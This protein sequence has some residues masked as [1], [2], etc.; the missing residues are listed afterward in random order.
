MPVLT[1][2][3]IKKSEEAAVNSGSFTYYELM[4]NAGKAAGKAILE[5]YPISG[6]RVAVLCGSGNNGGDG[7]VVAKYLYE[8]GTDVTVITPFGMPQTENASRCYSELGNINK[9]C[10]FTKDFDIIVDALFGIGFNREPEQHVKELFRMINESGAVKISVDIPSGVETDTGKVFGEAIIADLTLTFIA[11]KPCFVLPQGSDHCGKVEVLD[12]GVKPIDYS[13]GIIE[14]PV[15]EKRRH[16]SHKG[17]YGTALLICGSYGM[18]GAAMLAAKATLRSGAGL[19]KC[20]IPQ[21]IYAPFTAFIP[22]AVCLPLKESKNG[23]LKFNQTALTKQIDSAD[24]IL[25]GCGLGKGRDITKTLKFLIENSAKPLIIDAD[26]INSITD[27]IEIL[28][29][30]KA[31]IILTPHPGE[32]ARLCKKSVAEIESDR[33]YYAKTFATENNCTLVLKGSNT[34]V[35]E[36]D[37]SISFS[38]NGNPGM[39]TGGSGDVLSGIMVSLAAQGLPAETAAKY[40][41][42]LHAAAGDKAAAEKGQHA[43]LP[44]DIIEKL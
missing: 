35:A 22:E 4:Q 2:E 23:V 24:A 18:A 21:S 40:A 1:K 19:A 14:K 5:H 37:G 33:V 29:N 15:F 7:C 8:H 11:L 16:N 32:M 44:S 10:L 38:I 30:S 13:Y 20:V 27:C 41:V 6:R 3:L 36:K 12:I 26:G 43:L 42:Y 28:K 17:T 9:T 25:C 34:I 31:Q 39:A